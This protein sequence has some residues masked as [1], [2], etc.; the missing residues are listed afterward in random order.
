MILRFLL[1]AVLLVS[2]QTIVAQQMIFIET[3]VGQYSMRD[4]KQL[5]EDLHKQ[6]VDGG[7]EVKT[8]TSF[9]ISLQVDAG[10][11][12]EFSEKNS[13]GIYLNYAMTKG[14]I[15]Y[16]DYSGETYADQVVS[17]VVLGG[18]GIV[19]LSHGFAIYGKLGLNYSMLGM[20]FVSIIYG[21]GEDEE[22]LRFHSLGFNAEPG[23]LWT[24][25]K[26][27]FSFDIH[28]GYELNVQ[29]KTLYNESSG[30]YLQTE[31]GGNV[32]IN[33]TGIRTGIGINYHFKFPGKRKY[34][35]SIS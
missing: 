8:V 33:W 19:R 15:H 31:A 24:Y 35:I 21:N 10:Y 28:A 9:P 12:K 13:A 23:V 3:T 6:F 25:P 1:L 22:L 30:A 2:S 20:K 11:L 14:R 16:A 17:R 34:G 7:L 18:K 27:K 29:G 26:G 32:I 5:Q 4:L